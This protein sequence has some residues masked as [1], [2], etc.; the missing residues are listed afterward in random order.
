[1]KSEAE[2][3]QRPHVQVDTSGDIESALAQVSEL[4]AAGEG[5]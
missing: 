4:V 2:P 3:I 5:E 1:M